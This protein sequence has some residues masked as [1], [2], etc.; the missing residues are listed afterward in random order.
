M[1][2]P[3]I[4]SHWIYITESEL[5]KFLDDSL[6]TGYKIISVQRTWRLFWPTYLVVLYKEEN[7]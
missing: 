5:S 6:R 1:W 3:N 4:K 7:E 2:N